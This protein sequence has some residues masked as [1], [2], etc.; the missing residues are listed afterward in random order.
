MQYKDVRY[1]KT[2]NIIMN[3]HYII[4]DD[5]VMVYTNG[6]NH[7][8]LVYSAFYPPTDGKYKVHLTLNYVL[9]LNKDNPKETLD[10]FFKLLILQ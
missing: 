3:S 10:Q 2:F 5:C 1:W 7:T 8:T 9:E 6:L 4:I